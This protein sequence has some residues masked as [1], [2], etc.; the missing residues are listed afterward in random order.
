M[1]V[2]FNDRHREIFY[3]L[4]EAVNQS[5]VQIYSPHSF[6]VKKPEELH[7]I[8]GYGHLG[9]DQ[10]REGVRRFVDTINSRYDL[11]MWRTNRPTTG[12]T[13]R[14]IYIEDAH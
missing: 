7:L 4:R 11:P 9:E 13:V 1:V 8:F 3:S 2:K 10:I 14:D 6:Y 5:G 12:A